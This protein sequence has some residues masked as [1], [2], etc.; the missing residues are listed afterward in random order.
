MKIDIHNCHSRNTVL[1]VPSKTAHIHILPLQNKL[2]AFD[3]SA[4]VNTTPAATSKSSPSSKKAK[5]QNDKKQQ[6]HL[7]AYN[8][9]ANRV[10]VNTGSSGLM[11]HAKTLFC[12]LNAGTVLL[13]RA[14]TGARGGGIQVLLAFL[15]ALPIYLRVRVSCSLSAP[16]VLRKLSLA[17]CLPLSLLPVVVGFFSGKTAGTRAYLY[18]FKLDSLSSF[19]V[20]VRSCFPW[21]PCAYGF[22][23][24][25]ILY[26]KWGSVR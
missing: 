9:R 3:D 4:T 24:A 8:A 15:S 14:K 17:L 21:G 26:R 19:S 18:L 5:K 22:E 11:L 25:E 10:Q 12:I 13:Y 16:L 20:F 7:A 1:F 6:N 2:Y 23:S